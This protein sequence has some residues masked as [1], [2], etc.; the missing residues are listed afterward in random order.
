MGT[1][2]FHKVAG[3]TPTRFWINNPTMQEAASALEAGA[4]GC[5]TNPTYTAKMYAD[6]TERPSI[7]A[8]MDDAIGRYRDDSDAAAAVQRAAVGRIAARFLRLH[9]ESRNS[10]GWVS[11]QIS[12]FREEDPMAIVDDALRNCG[13]GP[14]IIPKIPATESGL[15]AIGE[16]IKLGIPI[17]VTEVMAISQAVAA[18]E[19]YAGSV[20]R[21]KP[22]Y[23]V[24]HISGI[25]DDYLKT[26]APTAHDPT[27]LDRT[28][29]AVA[30][31]QYRIMKERTYP[32]VLLG[33]GARGLHHFTELVGGDLHV[34][35]NW[36]KGA[37]DLISADPPATQRI[38]VLDPNRDIARWEM[39]LPDFRTAYS[40]NAL[41]IEEFSSFGPVVHFRN[42]FVEGWKTLEEAIRSRRERHGKKEQVVLS[43]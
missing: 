26:R 39:L 21:K 41:Q 4:V 5:T 24:T 3:Q 36:K 16:L 20:R 19:L 10:L 29:I 1:T 30:R 38:N 8:D 23:F 32:G 14:N 27:Y 35:L 34:T 11:I 18:C 22:V 6:S 12:P 7:E 9:E 2:Y 13:L 25:L 43:R 37:E 15:A 42:I 28:G 31:K 17:I 40:E 33:G